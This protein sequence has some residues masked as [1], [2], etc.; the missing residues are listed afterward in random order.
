MRKR[1]TYEEFVA[2]SRL[3]HGD[4]YDYSQVD[5]KNSKTKVTIICP[6]H[7][8]FE[9]KPEKHWIGHGCPQCVQAKVEATNLKKYGVR[10][11][12]QNSDIH[13]KM[14]K[15]NIERYGF[16]SPTSN[17]EIKEKRRQTV[18]ERYG[19]DY[20]CEADSVIA[21]RKA[22]N[23]LK[24]GGDT[25]FASK[26]VQDKS[27]QTIRDRYGVDNAAQ[28]DVVQEKMRETCMAKYGVEYALS[29][30][31]VQE[32]K[33]HTMMERYGSKCPFVS[34]DVREKSA[35]TLMNKYGVTNSMLIHDVVMKVNESKRKNNTFH[36]SSSEDVLYNRLCDKF[37]FDDVFRQYTSDLY[38]YACD[39]YIKSRDMYIELNASWTHGCCWFD[40]ANDD[41]LNLLSVWQEKAKNSEY[42][43]NAV[44]VWSDKDVQKRYMAEQHHLNYIVLWDSK[45][46]DAD[47][48]FAMDCPDGS[49]WLHE[50]SWLNQRDICDLGIVKPKTF[51]I[52][53]VSLLAKWYQFYVFFQCEIAL[54]QQNPIVRGLFLQ[55]Y[56]YWNRLNYVN[57]LP[58]ELTNLQLLRAFTI[59]GIHKGYTTFDISLMQ[60]VLSKYSIQSVYDPCAGWGERML[61]CYHN[62]VSYLGVDINANL[63]DG[64][65]A[66]ISDFSMTKQ[67]IVFD[68]AATVSLSGSVDA[69]IT[70]PPYGSTEIYSDVGAENLSHDDFLE[71]WK[72]VVSNSLNLQ[73]MYFCFQV[74]QKWKQEMSDVV[75]V[76]G[77]H[78]VEELTYDSKKSSHFT[79]K[80][81]GVNMKKEYESML[82]FRR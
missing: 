40:S 38:P 19:V 61:C 16:K 44:S 78:F 22:T 71:W 24:Y 46:R 80:K 9:Q 64:Y 67:S 32:K 6:K 53:N 43:E 1:M 25:P 5:Y 79:R 11:P 35:A 4:L 34:S 26:S 27:K 62:D 68:D 23:Q 55:M 13:K 14:E 39:F 54:W 41:A 21:K 7:G 17:D 15:T 52:K 50:Y 58:S 18:Q 76:C 75:E 36:T 45:L 30:A 33:N 47:V 12:L 49:D 28:S 66:M 57:K 56:L 42:Y 63:Q 37:G 10:R 31:S 8:P 65:D 73:P 48:W 69:V 2:K 51:G 20:T 60:N 82:V 3:V 72:N 70:C 77:F 29:A 81:G 59:A 74:N